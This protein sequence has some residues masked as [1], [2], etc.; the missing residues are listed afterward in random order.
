MRNGSP[1]AHAA[2]GA[3]PGSYDVIRNAQR[4]V[5]RYLA[6]GYF[7]WCPPSFRGRKRQNSLTHP[8]LRFEP[9]DLL[10]SDKAMI[11]PYLL[12]DKE[13]R[14]PTQK[15]ALFNPLEAKF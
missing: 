6:S 15:L 12:P 7:W 10:A 9:K 1:P 11:T 14:I 3:A 8:P 2:A 13:G 5:I 4:A